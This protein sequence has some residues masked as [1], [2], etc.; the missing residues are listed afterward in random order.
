M[1]PQAYPLVIKDSDGARW[2]VI[3][4][5]EFGRHEHF[6]VV[7]PLP[8]GDDELVGVQVA[9]GIAPSLPMTWTVD[10]YGMTRTA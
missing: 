6:P 4:W 1:I 7:V 8:Q 9:R 10:E 3:G 5:T 2:L